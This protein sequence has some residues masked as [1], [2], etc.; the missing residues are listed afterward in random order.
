MRNE[1]RIHRQIRN[2]SAAID[3]ITCAIFRIALHYP[4]RAYGSARRDRNMNTGLS[5]VNRL[6]I[7]Y[8]RIVTT[9]RGNEIRSLISIVRGN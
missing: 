5:W 1:N 4:F 6:G 7:N 3:F 9:T 8:E 2:R